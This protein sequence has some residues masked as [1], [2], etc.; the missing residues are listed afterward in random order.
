MISVS[1]KGVSVVVCCYNSVQRLS[2]TLEHLSRQEVPAHIP[3][4]VIIVD[5]NSTDGTADF[6][7]NCW[8]KLHCNISFRVVQE[9]Q[10]GLSAAR[11]KG[12]LSAFYDLIIFC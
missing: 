4:E 6:A 11:R 1:P 9:L 2:Q 7:A 10:P 3:W 12:F 8:K 5:N